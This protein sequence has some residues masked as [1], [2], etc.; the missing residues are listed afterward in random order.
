[1]CQFCMSLKYLYTVASDCT[2]V[3]VKQLVI[4]WLIGYSTFIAVVG[5]LEA[6]NQLPA[7]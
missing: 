3:K 1:M 7:G 6:T 2:C 5:N 4:Y